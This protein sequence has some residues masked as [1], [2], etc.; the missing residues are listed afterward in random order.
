M[1]VRTDIP[2]PPLGL[3]ELV[4]LT[5]PSYY[6][7]PAGDLVYPYLPAGAYECVFDFGCGCGRVARQLML[8]TTRPR[9]YLGI[10]IHRGMIAWCRENLTPLAPEFEF[11]H[12]D[13]FSPGLN[14]TGTAR[15]AR[16]PAEDG[17]FTLVQA[18]SVF[19][20]LTQEQ[21]EHYLR[22]A[23]RILRPDGFLHSTWFLFEK[24]YF[25]M[26]QDFQNTLFINDIDPTNAV[27]Y[28]RDW[29]RDAARSAGFMLIQ[30]FAPKVRGFQWTLVLTPARAGV[31]EIDLPEDD[32]PFGREPPPLL[33]AGASSFASP[34]HGQSMS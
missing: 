21:T 11:R 4:G 24:R 17:E 3:R 23:A 13:V 1:A 22:E 19:T 32:A 12:H 18:W 30:A 16:L 25:P 10:D 31:T 6:E 34:E 14:P 27:I 2:I 7:N 9:R 29:L 33:R 20:H 26:M 5:D 28:D 8:Q 15:L